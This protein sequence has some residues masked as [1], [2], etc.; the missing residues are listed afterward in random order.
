MW[1]LSRLLLFSF[2]STLATALVFC[3]A[4]QIG[5]MYSALQ[6]LCC[7]CVGRRKQDGNKTSAG[8][9]ADPSPNPDPSL[10]S[11]PNSNLKPDAGIDSGP[12]SDPLLVTME[13]S[14]PAF[15]APVGGVP[16]SGY[17]EVP[18]PPYSADSYRM[19]PLRAACKQPVKSVI[20]KSQH[21]TFSS[22]SFY[23]VVL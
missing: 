6:Q 2:L 18:S 22:N 9:V 5:A 3:F 17:G 13:D 15:A 20:I 16:R 12:T 10:Q 11:N 7:L 4:T 21:T 14:R 19:W 23:F 1:T 8:S